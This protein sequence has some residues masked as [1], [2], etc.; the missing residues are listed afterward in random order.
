ML[1]VTFLSRSTHVS[2]PAYVFVPYHVRTAVYTEKAGCVRIEK[3]CV[4]YSIAPENRSNANIY[5]NLGHC[6]PSIIIVM[7]CERGSELYLPTPVN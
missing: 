2:R 7:H 4:H 5:C 6:L 3:N 1:P